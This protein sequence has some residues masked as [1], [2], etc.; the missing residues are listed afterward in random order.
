MTEFYGTHAAKRKELIVPVTPAKGKLH[1]LCLADGFTEEQI[2][3][4]PDDVGS[5]FSVFSPVGLLPAA[6]MGLDVR[7]LLL[8]AASMTRCFMDEPFEHNP[9]LQFAAVNHLM[10]KDGKVPMRVLS[11]W[12]HKLEAVGHW[13]DH[14]LSESLS[15]H[16]QGPTPLTAVQTRDLHARGQQHQEGARDKMINNLVVKTPTHP[17]IMVGMMDR[18]DD[19]LNQYNRKGLP[20]LMNAALRGA[21]QA[22]FDV[23]RPTADLVLPNVTEHTMGQ[24][25][26]LLMLATVVEGRLLGINPYSQPGV[27]VYRRNMQA[28]LK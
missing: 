18:N 9:V 26:Q 20:D 6:L 17:P 2:L 14:L 19:D 12:S 3:T 10:N 5:R 27:E 21:N 22:Y 13:Y 23:A 7:A 24:L 25:L 28:L 11:I 8:G 16:N 1:D 15:K 4:I